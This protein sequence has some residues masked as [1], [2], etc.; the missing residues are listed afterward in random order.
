MK[1]PSVQQ[2]RFC[3]PTRLLYYRYSNSEAECLPIAFL[4]GLVMDYSVH[5]EAA[6]RDLLDS[7]SRR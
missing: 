1:A 4:Q 5:V 3:R 2:W 7:E 6:G